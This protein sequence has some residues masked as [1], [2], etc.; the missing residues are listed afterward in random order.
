[1]RK[2]KNP[3]A[4]HALLNQMWDWVVAAEGERAPGIHVS[5]L[6]NCLRKA[7]AREVG[8]V[9]RDAR[10]DHHTMLLFFIGKLFHAIA[11]LRQGEYHP[12]VEGVHGSVDRMEA[13]ILV[14]GDEDSPVIYVPGEIKTTRARAKYGPS[15]TYI[16]QLAAYCH[17]MGTTRG[18]LHILHLI[19]PA[20]ESWDISFDQA[21]IDTWWAELMRRKGILE[22]AITYTKAQPWDNP[23]FGAWP[24]ELAP[25][26]TEHTTWEC[27]NC[28]IKD[29]I[30]CPGGPGA[31]V[32]PF[33]DEGY[34]E[35]A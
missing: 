35:E 26:I 29:L 17:M 32:S 1:M 7:W 9:P 3:E 8:L 20:F 13:L 33:V 23:E 24:I 25:P 18:R 4:A 15:E 14:P 28:S 34:F 2:T 22:R 5:D 10:P 30:G 27:K 21:E 6:T 12:E 19:E 11:E 16:N 31:W